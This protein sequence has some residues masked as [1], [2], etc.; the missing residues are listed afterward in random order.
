MRHRAISIVFTV[1]APVM[2]AQPVVFS[3]D[4]APILFTQCTPCHRQGEGSPFPLLTFEDARKHAT[5]IAEVT[6]RRLMPPWPPEAGHGEF[7]GTRRLSDA[8]IRTIG[9]WVEAGASE[10]SP[11]DLPPQ[12]KFPVGWQLGTPDLVVTMRQPYPLAAGPG[13]VF[14]NFVL[15]VELKESKYI[16]AFELQPGERRLVHHANLLVDR[17]QSLRVRD[18]KDGAPG[19]SGMDVTTESVDAFDP[20]SHFLFWK[21]GSPAQQEPDGMAWR[22]DPGSDLIVNL[23]LQ[24]S[25]KPEM[26]EARLGL[27]FTNLPPTKHP[28]LLQLEHDGK[29][30]I[31]AGDARFVVTDSLKLPV[32]VD[33]LAIYPHAHYLGRKVEAWAVL[34]NGSKSSLLL[35][36]DW[37]MKWQSTYNYAKPLPLPAGTIVS[38]RIT[39][40]NSAANVRNPNQP[41][42]RVVGGNRS[43]DEM[44]HV[45]L[46]VLP[47][48]NGA[49]DPRLALQQATMRRGIEKYPA[50][51]EAHFNLGAALQ[52]AGKDGEAIPYLTK[53]VKIRPTSAAAHNSLATSL[54]LTDKLDAAIVELQAAIKSDGNYHNARYN[55][56]RARAAKGDAA[57]SIKEFLLYLEQRP[58]DVEAE[59]AVAGLLASQRDFKAAAIHYGKASVLKPED[60]DLAT[61][62]GTALALTGELKQAMKAFEQALAV[63]PNHIQARRNLD[64]AKKELESRQ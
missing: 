7:A 59:T 46:Q 25:G 8:Q 27:Y 50:D 61:N 37:D 1:L 12:P 51:F 39:F 32:A 2:E 48:A 3:K 60:A 21:P 33:L 16:R 47:K 29:L 55:L 41:P 13:D 45:W 6:R 9:R 64:L 58:S 36:N 44:G 40:D 42:R 31:P 49:G 10:G 24:P 17:A 63:D 35:I 52:A 56:A 26:V 18:G 11:A 34:P 4:V 30:D 28:M 5:Q 43:V 19:F 57:S 20:D 14:R 53:A 23:H 15:P 22:L 38:M 54:M 62:L